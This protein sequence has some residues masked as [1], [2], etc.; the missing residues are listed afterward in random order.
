MSRRSLG[1]LIGRETARLRVVEDRDD[2]GATILGYHLVLFRKGSR[3]A[4]LYSIAVDRRSRGRGLGNRLLDDAE[5]VA[6]RAKK[7]AL[8]LEVRSENRP[9]I[10]LYEQRGYRPIGRYAGYY[11]D[12]ADALRYEKRLERESSPS[13]AS[14]RTTRGT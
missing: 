9:A 10:A 6:L 2:G 8:R 12:K 7:R 14:R 1:R 4:R 5:A 11:A 13:P 3:V